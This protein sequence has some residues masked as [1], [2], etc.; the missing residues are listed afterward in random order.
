MGEPNGT[1]R[2]LAP[3]SAIG[4]VAALLMAA[5][6]AS[7]QVQDHGHAALGTVEF[8]I[9]CSAQ[10]AAEFNRAV[11]LLHHMTYPQAREAFERV[12][13]I[14]P[15]CAM[16]QWGVAMTL[17]QPLWPTRPGPE[18]LRRGWEAVQQ[19]KAL[20]PQAERERLF[21]AAAEA[22]FR[23]PTSADY[24]LRVRRWEQAMEKVYRGFPDDPEAAAFYALALLATA[25]SD[26]VSRAHAD[27]AAELLLGMHQRNPDHPGAMHYLLHANDMP[28]RER[29]SLEIT[30]RYEAVAPRNPH[31]LHMPTHIYTR[32]GDWNGV[33]RG[34]L[35]AAEAAL[36]HPA[37]D[38]GEFVWDEFPHAIE[39]L[40]NAYLE[41]GDDERA[42]EQL[43]RLRATP[44][45]E[46]TFKTAF[47][48]ASTQARY[49]LERRAWSEAAL[50]VPREPP[51]VD[52]DRFTW[53]EAI[54]WFARGLGAAHLGTLTESRAA[55]A[56]LA[57]LETATRTAG[58][59]LF[60]RN[61]A[62]LR[63]EL[64]G[65]LA[66]VEGREEA[67]VVMMRE[68]ADIEAAT[69][70]HAVTPGPTLPA[71]ELLGDL[72]LEQEHPREALA[73]YQRSLELYPR[74]FNSLLGA[75][76][77]ARALDDESLA[78]AY[79][80][81]LLD[82]ADGGTRQPELQEARSHAAQQPIDV[83]FLGTYHFA[84][85]G[86]DVVRTD[87]ADVLAADRQAEIIAI[88]N[89]LARFQPTKIAVER[90][91]DAAPRLDSVYAAYRAGDHPLTR[92]EI[93]Q[94]G[95]RLAAMLG[96]ERLSPIDVHGDFPFDA[97]MAYATAHDSDFVRFIEAAIASVTAEEN[98]RQTLSIAENLAL[99]NDP[100]DIAQGHAFYLRIA[101][102]GAGDT[103]VGADLVAKWYDRNIRIFAN[104]QR[105]AQ[106]G[107]RILVLFGSGHA[108]ILRELIQHDSRMRLIEPRDYLPH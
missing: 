9:S 70:K 76:R 100:A 16:A 108:A 5:S 20:Q 49:A 64:S 6:V 52:W 63:L 60:A 57:E 36:E 17:F 81:A 68:A 101:T 19:A 90:T 91:A 56:R 78:R 77:A 11:A 98:R 102:V 12:A 105:V 54:S 14:D 67:G 96:L 24:W 10:A 62:V 2:G 48:L 47:H 46:P 97:V 3:C 53:P 28:G 34:N 37:G 59:E 22:F 72:L 86:L 75:A 94:I 8:P 13:T 95:F 31:A 55:T 26:T 82:V 73:S 35:L 106:P 15:G 88:V 51:S 42:A 50:I 38:H 33:I 32:L 107:D 30:R 1:G 80:Q 93:Q 84:N 18:A 99:R 29:E 45:L 83:L 7:G 74:H 85:P 27:R 4:A 25:P 44:R 43:R 87:V 92:N 66:H 21:I 65:W 41:Q 69:P 71:E 39:Y 40:V 104:L 89:A 58:E 103:Y 79:Y 61:I 23:D